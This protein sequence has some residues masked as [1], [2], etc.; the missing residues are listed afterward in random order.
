MLV[1]LIGKHLFQ[2]CWERWKFGA[3]SRYLSHPEGSLG[4]CGLT[5]SS[6]LSLPP[7][8]ATEPIQGVP[9]RGQAVGRP[10]YCESLLLPAL[11]F[12][13]L[14]ERPTEL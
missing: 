10:L 2:G 7:T 5:R 3:P 14:V 1:Y 8:G 11:E 6:L 9:W 13:F 12:L 4:Q